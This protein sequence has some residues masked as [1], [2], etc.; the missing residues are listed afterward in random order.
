MFSS[1]SWNS[2][3]QLPD[4]GPWPPLGL[5]PWGALTIAVYLP[6]FQSQGGCSELSPRA[7]SATL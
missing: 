1:H 2:S 3:K 4:W 6:A 7:L 5:I